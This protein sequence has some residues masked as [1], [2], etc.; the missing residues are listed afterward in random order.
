MYIVHYLTAA[1]G[2]IFPSIDDAA[3]P[4]SGARF[5]SPPSLIPPSVRSQMHGGNGSR[6]EDSSDEDGDDNKDDGDDEFGES[7]QTEATATERCI[8]CR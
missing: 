7:E 5:P 3:S 8:W 4:S 6:L 2:S 1:V